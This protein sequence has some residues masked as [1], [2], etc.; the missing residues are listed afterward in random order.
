M[1]SLAQTIK[2]DH[3][4]DDQ[5]WYEVG[6]RKYYNK[7]L[8][9]IDHKQRREPIRWNYNDEAYDAWR[10]DVE[11][12]KSLSQLYAERAIDIR[13]KYDYIVLH[14]SGG[15][16]STNILETFVRSGLHLDEV[17]T[18]GYFSQM[19]KVSTSQ[20]LL[21]AH[22]QHVECLNQA[23]PLANMV[24][25]KHMPN[26]R[27]NAIDWVAP[28]IEYFTHN[29][30]W[31]ESGIN[32]FMLHMVL[33]QNLHLIDPLY[34]RLAEQGKKVCHILGFDKP[35]LYK[36]DDYY[37]TLWMDH[38][39]ARGYNAQTDGRDLPQFVELFYWGR[40]AIELQIKQL[41]VMKNH[42][43]THSA[44][45]QFIGDTNRGRAYEDYWARILYNRT[46]PLI[47]KHEKDMTE[48]LEMSFDSWFT[49]NQNHLAYQ[50]W[51]RGVEDIQRQVPDY[52]LK[53][54]GRLHAFR[55]RSRFLGH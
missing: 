41:H 4:L 50:N 32:D 53:S 40:Q 43:K 23:V 14:F 28:V 55:S 15:D 52:F 1:L 36:K 29:P 18:R 7:I 54:S 21:P 17:L 8:A 35:A 31:A 47:C 22:L 33:H 51:K 3:N 49:Q 26:L 6:N 19:P 45:E 38:K 24:K 13:N 10:W 16:D 34:Q 48:T 37:Y 27:I 46:L 20:L 11:P 39:I 5:G 44:A 25:E 42:A 9:L 12:S 2:H 30:A